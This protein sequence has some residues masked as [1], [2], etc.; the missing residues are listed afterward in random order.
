M[1][2]GTNSTCIDAIGKLILPEDTFANTVRVH[3]L[4]QYQEKNNPQHKMREERYCWYSPYCRYPLL[5]SVQAKN[6]DK[7]I[8]PLLLQRI[9]LPKSR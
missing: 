4:M 1:V 5:E 3:T 8:R 7:L 9:I 6:I 2:E